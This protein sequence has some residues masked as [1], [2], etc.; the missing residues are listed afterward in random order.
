MIARRQIKSTERSDLGVKFSRLMHTLHHTI[1]SRN[2]LSFYVMLL[3]VICVSVC[4]RAHTCISILCVRAGASV[5]A[6]YNGETMG[7]LYNRE[8]GNGRSGH[9]KHAPHQLMQAAPPQELLGRH[10]VAATVAHLSEL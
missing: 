4:V 10:A 8:T 6:L 3:Y 9:T 7:K 5:A 1:F 2:L